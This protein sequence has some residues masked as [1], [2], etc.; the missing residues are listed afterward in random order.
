MPGHDTSSFVSRDRGLAG[1]IDGRILRR[2]AVSENA[3]RFAAALYG[4][5]VAAE[6]HANR[7]T[8]AKKNG[9]SAETYGEPQTPAE[10]R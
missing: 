9:T 8:V 2:R 4:G 7:G 6:H 10:R 3:G 1:V 5:R